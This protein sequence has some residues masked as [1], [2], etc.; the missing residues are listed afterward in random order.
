MDDLFREVVDYQRRVQGVGGFWEVED[1]IAELEDS[2]RRD[3][4]DW[5]ELFD[6]HGEKFFY[7]RRTDESRFDDPRMSVYHRLY[8][9]IKMVAK[10]KERLP[11]LARALRPE[12]PTE[13]ELEMKRRQKEEEAKYLRLLI[14]IQSMARVIIAKKKVRLA[15]AK[16]VVQKGPQPLKGKLRLRMEK[17][18]SKGEREIVL[19]QTTPHRRNKAAT[20]IQARMRGVLARKRFRPLVIHRAYLSRLIIKVQAQIRRNLARRRVAKLRAERR[21]R[22]AINIQRVY[23]GYRDRQYMTRLKTEKIRF[24]WMLKQVVVI[25]SGMRMALAKRKVKRIRL[26][27][28]NRAALMLQRKAKTYM[29]QKEL[30]RCQWIDEPVQFVFKPTRYTTTL[31]WC[32]QLWSAPWA[33]GTDDNIPEEEQKAPFTNLFARDRKSVV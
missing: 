33:H 29:A 12:E 2:I 1:E 24:N 16:A 18:G 8:A 6:E 5:M 9:R 22:A 25:Q 30:F 23:R 3:L 11:L 27:K 32:W 10:M 7:N 21:V 19:S 14:R 28:H 26:F 15:M 20:R 4:A 13:Q 17:V 31:P